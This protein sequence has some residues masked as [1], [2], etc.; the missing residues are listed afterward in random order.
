MKRKHLYLSL[1]IIWM[2]FIFYNSNQ[3]AT[4]SMNHTFFFTEFLR[5]LFGSKID[6]G[7]DLIITVIR[8]LAHFTEFFILGALASK[9]FRYTAGKVKGMK[10][11]PIAFC[12]I[13]AVSDEIH[14]LFIEGRS[15]M[16]LDI[17]IDSIGASTAVFLFGK[18]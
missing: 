11:W 14:Q 6:F 7:S 2:G 9:T 8:K 18:Q 15:F 5:S 12:V 4:G 16:V 3:T 17:F 13:F 10:L 1:L